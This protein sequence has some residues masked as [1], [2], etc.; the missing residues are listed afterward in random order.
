[1]LDLYRLPAQQRIL[2]LLEV[3]AIRGKEV[4]VEICAHAL[5]RYA[6]GPVQIQN[7]CKQVALE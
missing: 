1:M 6:D 3:D 2:R 5:V 7:W 4:K